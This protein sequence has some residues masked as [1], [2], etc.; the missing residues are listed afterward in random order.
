MHSYT[1]D[2]EGKVLQ[3]DG[4]STARYAYDAMDHRVRV[5]TPVKYNEYL[6]EPFG[7]RQSTWLVAQNFGSEGKIYW[8]YG[9]LASC[10]FNGQTFFHHSNYLGTERTRTNYQ[11]QTLSTEKSGPF[12]ENLIEQNNANLGNGYLAQYFTPPRGRYFFP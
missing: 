6:F 12:G 2:A 7:R 1:Y 4:G 11:G 8:N 3:V 10:G 5:T 9:L